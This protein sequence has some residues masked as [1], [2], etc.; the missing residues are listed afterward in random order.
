MSEESKQR[1]ED[2]LS[3]YPEL[4]LSDYFHVDVV[5]LKDWAE[6]ARKILVALTVLGW[7]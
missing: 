4:D 6:K 5:E 7:K 1:L 2:F 3:K